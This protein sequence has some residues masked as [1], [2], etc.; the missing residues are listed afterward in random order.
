[1]AVF[2]KRILE[3]IVLPIGDLASGS[4]VMKELRWLRQICL[5]SEESLQ[6]LQRD[7]LA[8]L[9][10]HATQHSA[11]YRGLQVK[12][13]Q[14]P[15]EW[16]SRFPILTKDVVRDQ[17][18]ALLTES[19]KNLVE[20]SSSGSTGFQTTV[21]WNSMKQSR[22]RA[23]Q[24][25]WWEWAGYQLG[26]PVLQ[27]GITPL[28][29]RIRRLKDQI[30]PTYYLSAFAHSREEALKALDYMR[31]K[32]GKVLAGYASSLY[33][34]AQIALEH[35][36]T[37][38]QF[39]T[40][41]SWGDKLFGHYRDRIRE[42]F[43]TEVFENYGSAEGMTIA[44][45][46]DLDYPYIMTPNVYLEV[47]DDAGNPVPDGTLGHVVVTKPFWVCNATDPVSYRRFGHQATTTRVSR[48]ERTGFAT[49]AKGYRKR[50][51]P[52]EDSVREVHGGSFLYRNI[53]TPSSVPTIQSGPE[54]LGWYRNRIHSR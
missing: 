29:D 31:N 51:G 18:G 39:K 44:A 50:Y 9:L 25:L 40:A 28:R 16:L 30:L 24:L 7:E 53:R 22:F 34:L 33:V 45:Q 26:D 13:S 35:G 46:K 2:R 20:I 10:R 32:R 36:I 38:I 15:E 27:T 54:R 6:V 11:Y 5:E 47:V 52:G 8:R 21:L 4:R 3:H 42:A 37:D 14:D 17:K 1:M 19:T 23:T 48:K 41:I 49:F 43:D 12:P